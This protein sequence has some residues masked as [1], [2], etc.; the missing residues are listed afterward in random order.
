MLLE[1]YLMLFKIE[2]TLP[3]IEQK[4]G[5]KTTADVFCLVTVHSPGNDKWRCL[6]LP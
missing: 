6:K 5:E 3:R 4:G 2:I 1:R